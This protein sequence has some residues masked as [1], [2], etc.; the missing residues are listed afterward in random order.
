[1]VGLDL[2]EGGLAGVTEFVS[3]DISDDDSV[4]KATSAVKDILGAGLDVLINNA[5]VGSIGTV[6]DATPDQW[7]RVFG[8]NVFGAA[9]VFREFR[10]MLR[11]GAHP[12]IV[13]TSSI[14]APVSIPQR[15]IYSPSNGALE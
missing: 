14:V 3:C 8:A 5:G 1:M 12:V 4:S 2:N 10:P 7:Q 6:V 9:R 11:A 13:N 15:A